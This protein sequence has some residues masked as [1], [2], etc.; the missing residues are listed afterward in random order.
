MSNKLL[1]SVLLVAAASSIA[2]AEPSFT[3]ATNPALDAL[4]VIDATVE[5]RPAAHIGVAA[6]L[7][8]GFAGWD[9]KLPTIELGARANYYP[10]R[11]FS[12]LRVGAEMVYVRAFDEM[13]VPGSGDPTATLAGGYVGYKWLTASAISVTVDVGVGV[14][15]TQGANQGIGLVFDAIYSQGLQ[16]LVNVAVGY[17]F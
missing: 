13:T 4:G 14:A 6:T 9:S 11:D 16:P 15:H 8:Y 5:A 7:G 12:G 1:G 10:L 17:S 3:V 2:S